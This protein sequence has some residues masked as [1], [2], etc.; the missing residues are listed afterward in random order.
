M[1]DPYRGIK[2]ALTRPSS[3]SSDF[4]LNPDFK[5]PAGRKL[6][7]AGVLAAFVDIKQE[8]HL[9]LMLPTKQFRSFPVAT[10]HCPPLAPVP[11]RDERRGGARDS[12]RQKRGDRE[13][14]RKRQK[15]FG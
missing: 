8:P 11:P 9:I 3:S 2:Q 13:P 5:L 12:R 14:E 6:R 4:D 7:P 15:C 10:G 1:P